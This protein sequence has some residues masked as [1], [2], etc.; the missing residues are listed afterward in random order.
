MAE[1]TMISLVNIKS[2]LGEG[3]YLDG[4]S[5]KLFWVDINQSVLFSCAGSQV[6]KYQI[7]GN[8]SAVLFAKGDQVY[9]TNR[10]GIIC[11]GLM[12][13]K[14]NQISRTPIQYSPKEYRAND[15]LRLCDSLYMY[16][17]MRDTPIKNDGALILSQD[18][19]S[20]VVHT[21]M[22]IPNTF[23]KTP[24]SHSLLITDS[25]EGVVYKI[26]FDEA[27]SFIISKVKW[28]DLSHTDTTPDGGCISSDGRIFIAI[29]GGFKILE[30]DLNGILIQEFKLPVP[31]PTNC[32][33]DASESQLF[34]TSAYEGLT[35]YDRQKY[36]LSGSILT[37]D[38]GVC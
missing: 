36:P 37:V 3:L 8:I 33:L 14:I 11:Y 25:F 23:I 12:S 5:G 32:T 1:L 28:Y 18:G 17:V 26:T 2:E 35:E 38:I 7:P 6:N 15:G 22:A 10:G 13:G 19:I 24:N 27:W 4:N 30:L 20:K 21:G 16:G 29:W 31:R 34:V 9:L